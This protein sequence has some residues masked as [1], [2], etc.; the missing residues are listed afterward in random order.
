M[1]LKIG[2]KTFVLQDLNLNDYIEMEDAGLN[3]KK[4]QSGEVTIRDFRLLCYT[5]IHKVDKEVTIEWVGENMSINNTEVFKA[6][7]QFFTEKKTLD[8]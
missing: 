4:M 7:T 5:L 6:V 8:T 2:D 1:D 3:L